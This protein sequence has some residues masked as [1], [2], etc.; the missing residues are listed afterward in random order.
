[1][2]YHSHYQYVTKENQISCEKD[3][4]TLMIIAALFTI[5]AA[6]FKSGNDV[7]VH[8]VVTDNVVQMYTVE[9]Y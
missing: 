8:Q 4:C 1:M 9:Y 6:L 5:I 2:I 7:S 3:I